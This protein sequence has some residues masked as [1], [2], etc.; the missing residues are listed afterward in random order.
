MNRQAHAPHHRLVQVLVDVIMEVQRVKL[1]AGRD[2]RGGVLLRVKVATESRQSVVERLV[3]ASSRG[4]S[5]V[6][7]R[8]GVADTTGVLCIEVALKLAAVIAVLATV[9]T[10]ILEVLQSR[11]KLLSKGSKI[12]VGSTNTNETSG[13]NKLAASAVV[14]NIVA[15]SDGRRADKAAGGS[16]VGVGVG[17]HVGVE[18]GGRSDEVNH[19]VEGLRNG[20]L[21][22]TGNL[23]AGRTVGEPLILGAEELLHGVDWSI[24]LDPAVIFV[25]IGPIISFSAN[26]V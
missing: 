5:E 20:V 25:S 6:L 24:E 1:T 26:D 19:V 4:S 2:N 10:N 17:S 18:S 9:D 13:G 14:V 12:L 11:N 8:V 22:S 3:I 16:S 23:E 21:G 7:A 15:G